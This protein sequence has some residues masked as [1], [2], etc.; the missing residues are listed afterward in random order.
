MEGN[1]MQGAS[2]VQLDELEIGD[3]VKVVHEDGS[4]EAKIQRVTPDGIVFAL[5]S[6]KQEYIMDIYDIPEF[7]FYPRG[8][9]IIR[10]QQQRQ[11]E[12]KI[13]SEQLLE[14]SK[15]LKTKINDDTIEFFEIFER[16]EK[17]ALSDEEADKAD[18]MSKVMKKLANGIPELEEAFEYAIDQR[19]KKIES[20]LSSLGLLDHE[21]EL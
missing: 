4:F 2:L 18:A 17:L 7:D 11:K 6:N 5:S 20:K 16:Y 13:I 14:S 12:K 19:I 10:I 8:E 15:P 1:L 3:D 21:S 9:T